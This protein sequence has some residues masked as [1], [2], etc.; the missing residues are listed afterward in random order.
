MQNPI[1][2]NLPE[3]EELSDSIKSGETEFRGRVLEEKIEIRDLIGRG[4]HGSVYKSYH[5]LLAQDLAVKILEKEDAEKQDTVARFLR[6][7]QVLSSF[8]HE[9]IVKFHSFGKMPEG[10]HY[11]VME[12][13]DGKTLQEVLTESNFIFEPSSLIDMAVQILSGLA[14]AHQN[15]VIHRDLKPANI[16]ILETENS[17]QVKLLDFGILKFQDSTVPAQGLTKTGNILGSVNYMSPE[18]CL[19][20]KL[21]PASDLY[22]LAC[23]L[24][25]C[26]CGSPPMQD[27]NDL[28]IMKNQIEKEIKELPLKT[29]IPKGLDKVIIKALNKNPE[30]RFKNADEMA[31]AL[32]QCKHEKKMQ[33][34]GRRLSPFLFMLLPIILILAAGFYFFRFEAG[35]KSED[36]KIEGSKIE[37]SKI[38]GS[39]ITGGKTGEPEKAEQ[40]LINRSRAS[41]MPE[42]RI[43]SPENYTQVSNWIGENLTSRR[44]KPAELA[45]AF[46]HCRLWE[47]KNPVA[48]STFEPRISNKQAQRIVQILRQQEPGPERLVGLVFIYVCT[49]S[50]NAKELNKVLDELLENYPDNFAACQAA[51]ATV[52]QFYESKFDTERT[53]FYFSKYKNYAKSAANP[54][55][56][57]DYTIKYCEYLLKSGKTKL[58][59]SSLNR[60]E[61]RILQTLNE[62]GSC[63]PSE[64][65]AFLNLK[66]QMDSPKKTLAIADKYYKQVFEADLLDPK[67]KFDANVQLTKA[68][69]IECYLKLKIFERAE[70]LARILQKQIIESN[71]ANS[72]ADSIE[73]YILQAMKAQRK[74]GQEIKSEA[75]NYIVQVSKIAPS[76]LEYC[77]K[78][79]QPYLQAGKNELVPESPDGTQ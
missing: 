16:M 43:T 8:N 10:R 26:L 40:K 73:Q 75:E 35:K 65:Q 36:G 6:E 30:D 56:E 69:I 48:G 79:L 15:N 60:A 9:N 58:A 37:G 71:K 66:N 2:E 41:L 20:K 78:M 19:G 3:K 61:T 27:T 70:R 59:L 25:E 50:Y 12:Y 42:A 11:I 64:F 52:I 54:L 18:Q 13:L 62:R 68:I 17:K 34:G 22:A 67:G 55:A 76:R 7:A 46:Y 49:P 31:A 33:A 57:L 51:F 24:Y 5:R 29:N 4:A 28:L 72:H 45:S 39:K 77:R 63:N 47:I 23:I 53:E 74:T 21:G 32:S 38:E 14:Y 1:S 44:A